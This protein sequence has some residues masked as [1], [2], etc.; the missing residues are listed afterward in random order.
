[1]FLCDSHCQ[2]ILDEGKRFDKHILRISAYI[3]LCFMRFSAYYNNK[4]MRISAFSFFFLWYLG[5]YDLLSCSC[6]FHNRSITSCAM[7]SASSW[8][9]PNCSAVDTAF[10]CIPLAIY[11][12]SS[13]VIHLYNEQPCLN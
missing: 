7:S 10:A 4:S 13:C 6:R 3:R 11:V 1:M 12:N 8:E 9:Y 2:S 5:I